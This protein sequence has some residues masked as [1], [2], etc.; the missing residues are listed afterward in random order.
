MKELHAANNQITDISV[1]A[2]LSSLSMLDIDSN[3]IS[4]ISA[5]SHHLNKESYYVN[6]QFRPS[7]QQLYMSQRTKN[8][9]TIFEK[10]QDIKLFRTQIRMKIIE[11]RN[12]TISNYVK[13]LQNNNNILNFKICSL[14]QSLDSMESFQ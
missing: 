1:I 12:I 8:V 14:F 6:Y 9:F 5:I 7:L 4:D 11:F 2:E 3:F 13:N 10:V